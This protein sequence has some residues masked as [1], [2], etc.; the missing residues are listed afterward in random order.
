MSV[1]LLCAYEFTKKIRSINVWDMLVSTPS[2]IGCPRKPWAS[3]P[4]PPPPLLL[5]LL[6]RR[7]IL[8]RPLFSSLRSLDN[9]SPIFSFFE[10]K[11]ATRGGEKVWNSPSPKF[12]AKKFPGLNLTLH[13][14]SQLCVLGG[15]LGEFH[16]KQRK[17]SPPLLCPLTRD[18]PFLEGK[19]IPSGFFS[20]AFMQNW[21]YRT[22]CSR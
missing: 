13:Q 21:V 6:L 17:E 7:Y 3:V 9:V 2:R 8:V 1:F 11:E 15:K 5:L 22:V 12:S 20:T 4:P 18:N 14:C 19:K 10:K 16:P